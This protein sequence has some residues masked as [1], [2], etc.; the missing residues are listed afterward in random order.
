MNSICS[1]LC[2]AAITLPALLDTAV[3]DD[4]NLVKAEH[5]V[6]W[7][8]LPPLPDPLG[9]AGPFAGTHRGVLLVAGGANF[10]E[11]LPWDGG[12]K[13]WRDT[14]YVLEKPQGAWKVAG[15][16]PRPLAYGVSLSTDRGI[17]CLGGSDSQQHF[18]GCFLLQWDHGQPKISMLPSLPQPCANF[19]GA[20]LGTTIYV[21][22]GIETPTATQALH[23]FWSLDLG[24]VQPAWQPLE[25]W[26]GPAR[27]LAVAAVQDKSF[28]LCSGASLEAGPDGKPVRQ[29][30]RDAYRYRPNQ[31]WQRIA[32]LPRS[33]V[34]APT[35][36]PT[37]GQSSF[38]VLS[39]DDGTHVG[40]QPPQA[41]PGFPKSVLA[42][43]TI[44]NTWETWHEVPAGHVT[45]SIVHWNQQFVMPSGEI[46][47][48][49]RSPAVWSLDTK[50]DRP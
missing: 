50:S 31:G 17:A 13:V 46:R 23:T 37:L 33:A 30:L 4:L 39:G 27:M 42:Y 45:T 24:L 3:A 22:G 36:A 21:A 26:P 18:A 35:P 6:Q 32:D 25:P 11:K 16:L 47:P 5:T 19:C 15:Q 20:L 12:T 41:H 10:P 34:A 43:D 28:Y 2:V 38:L 49:V 29:Y 14:L 8:E 40:F 44:T 7:H 1:L 9:V 48:G